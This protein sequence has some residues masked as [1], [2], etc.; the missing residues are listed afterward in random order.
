[1]AFGIRNVPDRLKALK[2]IRRII[3]APQ[4]RPVATPDDTGEHSTSDRQEEKGASGGGARAGSGEGSVV[5]I[6]EL[7]DPE[8]GILSSMARMFIK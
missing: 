3:A 8:S 5:A 6:L 1:M 2:E 4:P 7:Q